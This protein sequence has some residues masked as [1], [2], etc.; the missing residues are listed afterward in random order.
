MHN[1]TDTLLQLASGIRLRREH[2]GGIVFNPA[3]GEVVD[4][5]REA[6]LLLTAI[7]NESF[8]REESL[9]KRFAAGSG[10]KADDAIG[11]IRRLLQLRILRRMKAAAVDGRQQ[12]PVRSACHGIAVR[13]ELIPE[14]QETLWPSE[15]HLSAPVTIH[16]AVTY[17]CAS[18]CPDCYAARHRKQGFEELGREEALC[19]IDRISEWGVFQLALGGGEPLLRPDL[20]DIAERAAGNKLVVHVTTGLDNIDDETLDKLAAGVTCLQTG[21]KPHLLLEQPERLS[22]FMDAAKQRGFHSGVNL[23]LNNTVIENFE[24]IIGLLVA[25]EVVAVTLLRYKPPADISRW[26]NEKPHS[27]VLQTFERTLTSVVMRHPALQVR[28]DCAL[29]FLQRSLPEDKAG[30]C[31]IRGCVAADRVAALSPDGSVYPCSQLVYPRFRAGNILTDDPAR[32]W[33][34]SEV[35]E[36][37]RFFRTTRSFR[38]SNCGDCA[39]KYQCGGCRV[40]AGDAVGGDPGCPEVLSRLSYPE[41][42]SLFDQQH[43]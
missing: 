28:V 25:A 36:R 3:T 27:E 16:W 40:F 9:L 8:V 15:P 39:V 6:F 34:R 1:Q 19:L 32:L 43:M 13:S 41:W 29:S 17:R 14:S 35:L 23:M 33:S 2:F 21:I 42:L 38:E 20:A 24:E 30:A 31:G 10:Y 26:R 22:H 37:Y 7:G 18:E 4:L 5:D 12:P 11:V